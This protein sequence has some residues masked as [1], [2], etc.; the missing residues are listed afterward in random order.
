MIGDWRE[1]LL[2]VRAD[3]LAVGRFAVFEWWRWRVDRKLGAGAGT[4][5]LAGA[6]RCPAG[7]GGA[8]R[9]LAVDRDLAWVTGSCRVDPFGLTVGQGD[10]V[11]V[12]A[13][14]F[15]CQ[16]GVDDGFAARERGEF[17][18]ADLE[19]AYSSG[20]APAGVLGAVPGGLVG[21][22]NK[23]TRTAA[24]GCPSLKTKRVTAHMLRHTNAMTLLQSDIST[25]VIA[26]WL[27]H[28]QEDT[29]RGYLHG[30]LRLKQRALDRTA[31]PGTRPGRYRAT[32]Q[33]LKFLESL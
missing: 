22:L 15:A 7:S 9:V 8:E 1:R 3:V 21:V 11:D 10:A 30:D 33:L 20:A 28:E 6:S 13:G 2:E 26:L 18:G 14:G 32:D 19:F 24:A 17:V 31:P 29:T 5:G 25:S 23:H 16:G 12:R 4:G 27:G